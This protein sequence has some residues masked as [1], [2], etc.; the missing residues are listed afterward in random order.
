M[1]Y[2]MYLELSY[3]WIGTSSVT[4]LSSLSGLLILLLFQLLFLYIV[5][6]LTP[7]SLKL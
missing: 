4:N 7:S 1:L 3:Q 2:L 5:C 6:S